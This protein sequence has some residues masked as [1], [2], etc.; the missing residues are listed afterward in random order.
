MDRMNKT[1][2]WIV[3]LA[4]TLCFMV[5]GCT[6]PEF[7]TDIDSTMVEIAQPPKTAVVIK[8]SGIVSEDW[9]VDFEKAIS[10][11]KYNLI[12]LWIES[13]GGK[14]AT[15]KLLSHKLKAYQK[16]YDKP[17]YV[18]SERLLA[19]GAYWV[20]STFDSIYISPAGYTGSIGVYMLRIG[21]REFYKK[22][23]LTLH[24]IASDSTKVMGN[25]ASEMKD[26]ER[27]Y[28]QWLIDIAHVEFMNYV[29][30][31]RKVQLCNSYKILQRHNVSTMEDTIMVAAQ[32]RQIA[33]GLLYDNKFA[34]RFGLVDGVM[35]FD[36]FIKMLQTGG[37]TII[38]TN[39]E[40]IKDFYPA[41]HKQKMRGPRKPYGPQSEEHKRKVSK[42]HKGKN[43]FMYGKHHS[44][45]TKQKMSKAKRGIP[46]SEEHKRALSRARRSR[47]F[48]EEK[49]K[50]KK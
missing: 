23:G 9:A 40:I 30:R 24:F 39:G 42:M 31:H 27:K 45:E 18:Y 34:Y 25:D 7:S 47:I 37:Y 46:L 5:V 41:E 15:T 44:E 17:V 33:N 2:H 6:T 38:T 48:S 13:P 3:L 43:N 26:W 19:S 35:Y 28:W 4:M 50:E 20:A 16:K 29:W 49:K 10:N 22:W 8:F 1:K 14:L 36:N 11:P 32:F 12:V 21:A